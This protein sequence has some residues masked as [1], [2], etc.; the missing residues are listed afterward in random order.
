MS[1]YSIVTLFLMQLPSIVF[2]FRYNLKR[3]V[4]I[5]NVSLDS[6]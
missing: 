1:P 2:C 3:Y 4:D 6:L 5:F